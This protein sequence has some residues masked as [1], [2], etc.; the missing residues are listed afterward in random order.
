[1]QNIRLHSAFLFSLLLVAA[2]ATPDATSPMRGAPCDKIG[3]AFFDGKGPPLVCIEAKSGCNAQH[4]WGIIGID[5]R[6]IGT[7]KQ[8][9]NCPKIGELAHSDDGGAVMVCVDDNP[10]LTPNN[11]TGNAHAH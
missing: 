11:G 8:N 4:F 2:C 1:M 5:K 7:E 9:T 10:N 3:Q 6:V